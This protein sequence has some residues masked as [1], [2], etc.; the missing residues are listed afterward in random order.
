M[1][2]N[3]MVC[4]NSFGNDYSTLKAAAR[5]A[6]EHNA[7]LC[8]FYIII[9]RVNQFYA[10]EQL[11]AELMH[12]ILEEE[13]AQAARAEEIFKKIAKELDCD[14]EWRCFNEGEEPVRSLFYTDLVFIGY[15]AQQNQ[16]RF[17]SGGFINHLLLE[18]GRPII[19]IPENWQGDIFGKRILLGWN[20]SREASRAMHTAIPLMQ[21]AEKVDIVSVARSGG[22]D[23]ETGKGIEICHFL[24]RHNIQSQLNIEQTSDIVSEAGAL[25][26]DCASKND[27]DLIAIGGYGHSRLR[28]ILLGGVTR[29]LLHN[30]TVPLLVIH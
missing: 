2:K 19:V 10:Y 21:K 15:S 5:F 25:I 17:G 28:E 13:K 4:L 11:S 12:K 20:E 30:S 23:E 8:G 1:I 29:Y 14:Y 9:D 7:H 27:S 18:S 6:H 24:A 3:I 22:S 16:S 26:L